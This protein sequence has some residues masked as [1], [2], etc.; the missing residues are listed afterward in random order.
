MSLEEDTVT[1]SFKSF[2]WVEQF[3]MWIKEKPEE[4]KESIFLSVFWFLLTQVMY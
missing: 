3:D 2:S 4:F 1:S